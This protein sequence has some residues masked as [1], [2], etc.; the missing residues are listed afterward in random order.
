M[1]KIKL[2]SYGTLCI[3]DVQLREFGQE[4]YVEPKT[5][6]I[7][8]FEIVKQKIDGDFYNVAIPNPDASPLEGFIVHI[9]EDV[10]P[11]VD[12]YETDEYKRSTIKTLG[13]VD[14]IMYVKK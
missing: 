7:S 9:P 8:G 1:E 5:D 13:G 4:F 6:F 12:E 14:C 11:L 3:K 10:M 2:F